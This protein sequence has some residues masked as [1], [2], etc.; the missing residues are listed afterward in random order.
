M[1]KSD[2]NQDLTTAG[3]L[4]EVKLTS[5]LEQKFSK[6]ETYTK[7]GRNMIISL[8]PFK[9]LESNS[10]ANSKSFGSA[11]KDGQETAPHIFE[12]TANAYYNMIKDRK[13][14]SI[15]FM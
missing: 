3:E 2:K 6:D 12:L 1:G 4:D 10:D 14:Q 5:L 11:V 7:V 15:L 13:D 9:P 8:N